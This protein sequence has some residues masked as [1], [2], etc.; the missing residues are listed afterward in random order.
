MLQHTEQLF[1]K[2]NFSPHTKMMQ[3]RISTIGNYTKSFLPAFIWALLILYLSTRGKVNVPSS[4]S[5]LFEWDKLGHATFYMIL[6]FALFWGL[7]QIN[8]LKQ[9]NI[10]VV[11]IACIAYGVILEY[12]QYYFFPGRYLE[13]NDMIANTV[14]VMISLVLLR[15]FLK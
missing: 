9:I 10:I 5:D 7:K 15:K 4:F 13:I 8:A 11:A 14:G 1:L 6:A 2:I 12:V 3:E